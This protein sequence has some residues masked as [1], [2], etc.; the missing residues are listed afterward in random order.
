M[1]QARAA[2]CP[3]AMR[4]GE[5]AAGIRSHDQ[6]LKTNGSNI[7]GNKGALPLSAVVAGL[8]DLLKEVG[9]ETPMPIGSIIVIYHSDKPALQ[10]QLMKPPQVKRGNR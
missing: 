6:A 8:F 3:K 4:T 7:T 10:G 9:K 2:A 1:V 5:A